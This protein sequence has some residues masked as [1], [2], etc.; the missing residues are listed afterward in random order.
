MTER[1]VAPGYRFAR[2]EAPRWSR[3]QLL[4]YRKAPQS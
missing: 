3:G 4:G 2:S 1:T